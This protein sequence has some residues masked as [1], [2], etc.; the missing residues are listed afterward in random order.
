MAPQLRGLRDERPRQEVAERGQEED[1]EQVGEQRRD[2]ARH[3][4]VE[5]PEH[6]VQRVGQQDRQ[7]HEQDDLGDVHQ[8]PDQECDED[9]HAKGDQELVPELAPVN[10]RQHLYHHA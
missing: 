4:T 10:S 3:V 7:Q 5:T 8:H 2:A 9:D 6:R 1:G